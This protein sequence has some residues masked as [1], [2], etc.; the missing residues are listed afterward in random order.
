MKKIFLSLSLLFAACQKDYYRQAAA[1]EKGGDKLSAA[2]YYAK[3]AS[4]SKDKYLRADALFRAGT[5]YRDMGL[6]SKAAPFFEE[7]ARFYRTSEFAKKADIYLYFCPAYYPDSKI[8]KLV[9]GDS[10]TYGRNAREELILKK[11]LKGGSLW[12]QRIYAGKKMLSKTNTEINLVGLSIFEKKA[13]ETREIVKYPLK[14]GSA[15]KYAKKIYLAESTALTVKTK[16][17]EFAGCARILEYENNSFRQVF[18]YAPGLGRV[19]SAIE[20]G[21]KETRITELVSYEQK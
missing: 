8:S 17:G 19:V 12:E 7:L 11:E 2:S 6:C 4:V 15:W 16:A 13:G 10:Q 14:N 20:S 3:Y 9:Y 1:L 21:G 5:I 18:Y